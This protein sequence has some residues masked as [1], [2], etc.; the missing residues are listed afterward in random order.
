MVANGYSLAK[1]TPTYIEPGKSESI[2]MFYKSKSVSA[3]VEKRTSSRQ[4]V[5]FCVI[6]SVYLNP[7]Q[8]VGFN[9][10]GLN[11]N[12]NID[13]VLSILRKPNGNI[14]LY[15]SDDFNLISLRYTYSDG[16]SIL[17]DF[18]YVYSTKS[19]KLRNFSIS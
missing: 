13:D 10:Q 1:E 12:S 7:S 9:Y 16:V 8:D 11:N 17:L 19:T 4:R 2:H 6:T 14:F 18:D 5:N 3:W 15:S